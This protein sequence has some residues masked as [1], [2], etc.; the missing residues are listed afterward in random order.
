M[1]TA[2]PAP[3]SGERIID[4]GAADPRPGRLE[5]RRALWRR[6]RS[7]L[8]TRLMRGIGV[9]VLAMVLLVGL[10]V[11]AI[12]RLGEAN[13]RLQ[14]TF[15]VGQAAERLYNHF[16]VQHS[17]L[18]LIDASQPYDPDTYHNAGTQIYTDLRSVRG[19]VDH[20]VEGE[21]LALWQT[22]EAAYLDGNPNLRQKLDSLTDLIAVDRPAGV[23][24]WK[25]GLSKEFDDVVVLSRQ[26]NERLVDESRAEVDRSRRIRD[27]SLIGLP[28]LSL[29][30][31]VLAIALSWTIIRR[32]VGL[33][34]TLTHN[35]QQVAQGNLEIAA[36]A[37][38]GGGRVHSVDELDQLDQTYHS[39]VQTLRML[40][41]Q[42]QETAARVS[43]SANDIS[44]AAGQQAQ[45]S[46]AQ[47]SAIEQVTATVEHLSQTAEHIAAAATGVAAAAE[48]ALLSA[49]RGQ[50]V[51]RDS[52]Q[53]MS[54][55]MTRSH[56]I[57]T[58]N[59]A[60]L[61]QSRRISEI[62]DVIGEIANRTHILA[63][64]AAI[65]SVAAGQHGR[66][67]AIIAA[68]VKNLAQ[69]SVAATEQVQAIIAEIQEATA[70][71]VTATEAGLREADRGMQLAQQSGAANAEIIGAAERTA[72]LA[73]AISLA[74]EQQRTAS[75]Q[76]VP[77]MHQVGEVT[78]QTATISRQTL[79]VV[80]QLGDVAQELET[81]S[82]KFHTGLASDLH[83]GNH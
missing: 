57:V 64:N 25:S 32:P 4:S 35:L 2:P 75:E 66:R 16:L 39:M 6:W 34:Q 82:H 40:I 7:R 3:Q 54:Q 38:R 12:T 60:L 72:Q 56:E 77:T 47:A 21:S 53:G 59:H 79:G 71:A 49:E 43:S 37:G 73:G 51:V 29:I 68:E 74:T 46:Y 33:L 76:M 14:R 24:V 18:H 58:R 27:G 50:A 8:L 48:Q 19:L 11:F 70:A 41:S 31:I 81:V 23:A 1:D 28:V 20:Q 45:G 83:N 17:I 30:G 36:T 78:R 9:A 42:M 5:A 62:I 15:E 10:A 52:V 13:E 26:L 61:D 69:N 55:I 80:H 44:Q 67:F 22:L 65:E 63:L